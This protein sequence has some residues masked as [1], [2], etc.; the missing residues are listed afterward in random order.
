[1]VHATFTAGFRQPNDRS[2]YTAAKPGLHLTSRAYG[3]PRDV[4]SSRPWRK[5]LSA[6][7]AKKGSGHD[8]NL[9]KVKM[10]DYEP[11]AVPLSGCS[12]LTPNRLRSVSPHSR[13]FATRFT[14]LYG[15]RFTI[16]SPRGGA[17]QCLG[18]ASSLRCTWRLGPSSPTK[19]ACLVLL[20]GRC[21]LAGSMG[22]ICGAAW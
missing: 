15:P 11:E 1:M 4:A 17:V 13:G 12:V 6:T 8:T 16:R 3:M 7:T 19:S 21:L 18:G 9:E 10:L 20:G 2:N 5:V 22:A 14:W